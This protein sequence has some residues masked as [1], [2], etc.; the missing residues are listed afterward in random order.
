M[1]RVITSPPGFQKS[2]TP[3]HGSSG[4][5]LVLEGH[6]PWT[7]N[8]ERIRPRYWSPRRN[9]DPTHVPEALCAKGRGQRW[10]SDIQERRILWRSARFVSRFSSLVAGGGRALN[11][12]PAER[13]P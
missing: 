7:A 9:S 13:L 5:V 11:H 2:R 1:D 3:T 10:P 6:R 8:G 4:L 12:P